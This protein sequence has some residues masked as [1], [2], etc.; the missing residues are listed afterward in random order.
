ML[1]FLHTSPGHVRP[2]EDLVA[3]LDPRASSISV[4]SE[5]LL[6]RARSAGI[7][8]PDVRA[9]LGFRLS[10]LSTA[11]A[12]V[13]LCTCSTVGGAAEELGKRV[14]LTVLRVDRAMAEVAVAYGGPIVVVATLESTIEPT[15]Q[16]LTSVADRRRPTISTR[17][18]QGAWDVFEAGDLD[19]YHRLI[20]D[21]LVEEA[22]EAS[23]LVLAQ[24][25][26]APAVQLV[27]LN[28]PILSSPRLGVKAALALLD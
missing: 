13:V 12:S 2:F 19:R 15:E 27:D 7:D 20:A 25:S 10:E 18:V 16:L 6:D 8:H 4:V 11:G 1:G 14:G 22:P 21:G 17:L 5:P 24:A 3:E 26:M 28:V 23:V 9:A